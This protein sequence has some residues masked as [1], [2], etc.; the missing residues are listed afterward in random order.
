M[1][2]VKS[3]KAEN[4]FKKTEIGEI[5]VDW[6]MLELEDISDEIYRYPNYYNIKYVKKG[7]PEVRGEL[8]KTNGTLE[9]DLTKYRF[10][11]QETASKFP[12]TR[13]KTGDFVISVRGTLGKVAII[14]EFLDGANITANLIRISPDKNKIISAYFIQVLLSERFQEK[15]N[16]ISS[17][18]TIKT[19]KAPDLK[20]LKFSIPSLPEQKEI[21]EILIAVDDAIEKKQAVI[22]KTQ[23]L[24]K[25]LVQQLLTRGIGHT[26]FK[27]SLIGEIPVGW[28]A[29]ILLEAVGGNND[30]I[31]AG[32][33]GSN[34]MVKDYKDEGI[35]IIRL[36]NIE[37]G[38]FINKDIKYISLEKAEKLNYHS[39]Q[40][41][42]VVLAKLGDPIGKT[43][44]IPA[45]LEKGIVVADVVRIRVNENYSNKIFLM[46]VM[47]SFYGLNQLNR[48]TIG[49]TRP[50]VNL[51][52]IRNLLVPLPPLPEQKKIADI[53]LSLDRKIE[54][55]IVEKKKLYHL[56][57][58]LMQ[59]L[60]IG[61]IRVG[62]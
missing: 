53:L 18:T 1:H 17:S 54:D 6:E 24:I 14:P 45:N 3:L 46:Y 12:R 19:I 22:K 44:I 60:L 47:N 35:P 23:T 34:L 15:L 11:S 43:C 37:F 39:F 4:K 13:L 27:Q 32:P 52:Q 29:K 55:E 48:E 10:I 5:P 9:S 58:G 41:G 25:G 26:R 49:T 61:K 8:I 30:Q 33:F 50:R 38:K 51:G 42:D 16:N 31:V 36:Q 59:R 62:K 57:K 40:K 2:Q 21:A 7:V 20:E 56:K 28:E